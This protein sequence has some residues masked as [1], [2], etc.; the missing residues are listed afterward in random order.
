V[1]AGTEWIPPPEFDVPDVVGVGV[2]DAGEDAELLGVGAGEDG[3]TDPFGLC[4]AELL[5]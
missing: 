3:A 4:G 1:G 5:G 2:G